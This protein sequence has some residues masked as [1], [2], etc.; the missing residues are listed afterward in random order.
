MRYEHVRGSVKVASVGKKIRKKRLK[1]YGYERWEEGNMLRRMADA[2]V[3]GK[4]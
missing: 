4:K 1:W 3:P 2:S